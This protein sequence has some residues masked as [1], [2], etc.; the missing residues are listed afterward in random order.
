MV[1]L[2]GH[3]HSRVVQTHKED[4]ICDLLKEYIT[5]NLAISFPPHQNILSGLPPQPICYRAYVHFSARSSGWALPLHL[6]PTT[7]IH[8]LP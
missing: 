3:W 7:Q 5:G 1:I 4:S 6:L 8:L 2:Q